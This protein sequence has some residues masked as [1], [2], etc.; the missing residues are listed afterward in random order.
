MESHPQQ[1]LYESVASLQR[2]LQTAGIESMA[3]GGLAIMLWGEPR[4]TRDADLKILLR[5]EE[6]SKRLDVLPAG[7]QLHAENPLETLQQ[8]GFLF[9]HDPSGV[10]LDLML[11][12]MG[13]DEM[14]IGR[15]QIKEVAVGVAIQVCSPEDLLIYKILST[16]PRDHEDALGVMRRQIKTLDH[17]YVESWL[18]NFEAAIDDSTLLATYNR[19]KAACS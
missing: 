2:T 15:R 4:L 9:T 14:A 18:Q 7:F 16:R 19:M 17:T 5:R 11:T 3:I 12:D 8:Y 6:A 1:N 10:R 13:F